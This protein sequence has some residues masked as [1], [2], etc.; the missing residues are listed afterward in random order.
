MLLK[1]QVLLFICLSSFIWSQGIKETIEDGLSLYLKN[2]C[3]RDHAKVKI[4]ESEQGYF[5]HE[6]YQ[7]EA[8][9]HMKYVQENQK[10]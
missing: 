8:L 5:I 2:V 10:E 1:I 4:V 6:D 7:H 3:L 9:F